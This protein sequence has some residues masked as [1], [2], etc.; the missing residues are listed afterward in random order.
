MGR[1]K[2]VTAWLCF[3]TTGLLALSFHGGPDSRA[4]VK[5]TPA[6]RATRQAN[7]ESTNPNSP[8]PTFS[9]E[10]W[11]KAWKD[12][13]KNDADLP[14]RYEDKD[15]RSKL[16]EFEHLSA[17]ERDRLMLDV[18]NSRLD[19]YGLL[20]QFMLSND[21][22]VKCY[23]AYLLGVYR[24]DSGVIELNRHLKLKNTRPYDHDHGT[25]SAF[26]GE[27]PA[28]EALVR[29]GDPSLL[30]KNLEDSDDKLIRK[31]SLWV[32]YFQF[33]KD[34][35]LVGIILQKAL[36]KQENPKKKTRLSVALQT[37]KST[38]ISKLPQ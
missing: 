5:P 6:S 7:P 34:K 1:F 36:A 37:L 14:L 23:G 27:Y 21:H 18:E 12:K 2:A 20:M 38:D 26:W 25:Y 29:M 3:G 31:L 16:H 4:E 13:P 30:V 9:S 33:R 10:D 17:K 19:I 28:A 35:D 15:V 24:F 22:E 8:K 32:L 11:E